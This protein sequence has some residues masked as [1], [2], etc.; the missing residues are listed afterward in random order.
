MK[1]AF[2]T[3]RHLAGRSRELGPADIASWERVFESYLQNL[4]DNTNHYDR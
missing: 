2:G 3:L 1:G 4:L